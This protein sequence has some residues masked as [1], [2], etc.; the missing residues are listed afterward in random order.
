MMGLPSFQVEER[1]VQ[2]LG[3]E[4]GACHGSSNELKDPKII[5]L[6]EATSALNS[7]SEYLC[8]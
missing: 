7:T 4:T 5:I 2:L 1:G 3:S 6:D 8:L